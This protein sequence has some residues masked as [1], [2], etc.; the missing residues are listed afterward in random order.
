MSTTRLLRLI[1]V[2]LGTAV[3]VALTAP[4]ASVAQGCAMCYQSAAA[5]GPRMIQALR[6][7]IFILMVPPLF[8]CIGITYLAYRRRNLHNQTS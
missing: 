2:V 8:I 5:S 7:G 6:D 1:V 3:V 4:P